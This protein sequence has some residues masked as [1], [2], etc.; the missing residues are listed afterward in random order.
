MEF[1][2]LYIV[3]F[4]SLILIL[5][6]MYRELRGVRFNFNIFFLYFIY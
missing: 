1:G 5:I 3:S 2:G 4:I 6:L